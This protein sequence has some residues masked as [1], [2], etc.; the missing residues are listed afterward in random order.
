[1]QDQKVAVP[2]V[3]ECTPS[4]AARVAALG[5]RLFREA[6][7]PTHPEPELSRY[8]ARE[9]T[10]DVFAHAATQ[11]GAFV[12]VVEDGDG[13]A[14]GYTWVRPSPDPPDG[15]TGQ[16]SAEIVR[17]YVATE[18]QRQG[19][20]ALLMNRSFELARARGYDTVWLQVWKEAPWAIAF[21]EKMGFRIVGSAFFYFGERIG[22]DH[23]M[24]RVVRPA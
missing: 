4:D 24:E 17:F 13:T 18:R 20:G 8:L 16:R 6:Y 21:Y 23:V 2:S 19:L 11:E 1:M 12:L 3:R 22:H 9:Y 10:R 15:V 7:G 5:A 14:I